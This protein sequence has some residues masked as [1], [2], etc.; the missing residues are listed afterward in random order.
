MA[1]PLQY[2]RD[3]YGVPAELGRR[4]VVNGKPGVIALDRGH[5]IGVNFDDDK[6]GDVRN[7]H[8]TDGVVYGEMGLIRPMT[9]SQ[10]RYAQFL[11]ADSGLPFSEWLRYAPGVETPVP[12]LTP[13]HVFVGMSQAQVDW[14]RAR[15]A[16]VGGKTE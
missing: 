16:G 9:R 11:D 3:Y 2:V 10:L 7:V 1:R 12:E 13:E 5:Y 4:V 6:P 15:I 8:P 14:V